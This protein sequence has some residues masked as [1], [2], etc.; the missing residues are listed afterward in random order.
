MT[1][2]EVEQFVDQ[3]FIELGAGNVFDISITLFI[4]GGRCLA[5]AYHVEDLSAVWCFE[6][7]IIEFHDRNGTL[8]RTLN[9]LN[10]NSPSSIAV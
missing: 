2:K 6:D 8:L 1:E 7:G 3:V 4:D 9:L 5:I 10:D